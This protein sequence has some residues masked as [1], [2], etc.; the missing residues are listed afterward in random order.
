[1]SVVFVVCCV[2]SGLCDELITLSEES[3]R[4]CVCV[5]VC[6]VLVC[7]V[8]T[9]ERDHLGPI[10]AVASQE[11]EAACMCVFIYHTYLG[12]SIGT[13]AIVAVS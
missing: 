3:Y 5:C 10:W 9:S 11:R 12:G 2:G 7:D 4:V 6:V 13:S 1:L 8:E